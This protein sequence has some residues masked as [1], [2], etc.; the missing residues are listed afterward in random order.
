MQQDEI[1]DI[2][3]PTIDIEGL[4]AAPGEEEATG[5][6]PLPAAAAG[7]D[8]GELPLPAWAAGELPVPVTAVPASPDEMPIPVTA[9]PASPDDLV[10]P[11]GPGRRWKVLAA[12]TALV[13]AGALTV[14][15]LT[16]RD[17][18][19]PA[20]VTQWSTAPGHTVTAPLDGRTASGLDL[21]SSASAVTVRSAAL[22]GDLYRVTTPPD[23]ARPQAADAGGRIRLSL[24][25]GGPRTVEILLNDRVSWDLGI[26]GGAERQS[27]DLSASRLRHVDLAGNAGRIELA[28]PPPDGTLTVRMAGGV[29]E[30][31]VRTAD[32]TPVRV[33]V[34][35]GA[36]RV[37]LDGR[38]H[39]GV[40]AGALLTPERWDDAGG[41]VDLDAAAGIAQLTVDAT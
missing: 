19:G 12:A 17:D 25:G 31:A 36:G 38:T 37:V 4:P 10:P 16:S 6:I 30:L 29:R 27:F 39:A 5:E 35:S 22:D 14:T 23:A 33:R 41:R 11:R 26:A 34:G 9:V 3:E 20:A 24:D 1:T 28:L 7:E 32:G 15:A 21:V 8:T 40:G 2:D 18:P 13:L